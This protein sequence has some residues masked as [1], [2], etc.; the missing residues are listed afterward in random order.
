MSQKHKNITLFVILGILVLSSI[1]L[2]LTSEKQIN[3]NVHE[4]V[5]DVVP[6]YHAPTKSVL[7]IGINT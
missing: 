5:C 1:I 4:A 2:E 6:E 3:T 7:A